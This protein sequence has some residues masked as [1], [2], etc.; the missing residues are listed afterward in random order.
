MVAHPCVTEDSQL[1][2]T[3]K[4]TSADVLTRKSTRLYYKLCGFKTIQDFE[5]N[6]NKM[7]DKKSDYNK[8]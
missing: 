5:T 8:S 1:V 7:F 4:K 6:T 3:H 2:T